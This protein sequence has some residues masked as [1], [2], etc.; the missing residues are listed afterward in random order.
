[1][2]RAGIYGGYL[3]S[4]YD[5][6][7]TQCNAKLERE[8]S[9]FYHPVLARGVPVAPVFTP[10]PEVTLDRLRSRQSLL[11]QVDEQFARFAN[12]RAVGVMRDQ[13]RQAFD[14]LT[15]NRMRQAFDLCASQPA[16]ANV[17]AIRSSAR[18]RSWHAGWS[19]LA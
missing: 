2:R 12:S 13:Q 10:P 16:S 19:R 17:M 4:Q 6:L 11:G 5:P 14:M 1:M 9:D 18:A 15:S 7:V 3:G 8:P